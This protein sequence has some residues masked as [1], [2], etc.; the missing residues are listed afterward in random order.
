M[1]KILVH[2]K[3]RPSLYPV[4]VGA[5]VEQ[6]AAI[7]AGLKATKAAVICSKNTRAIAQRIAAEALSISLPHCVLEIPDGEENKSMA[8]LQGLLEKMRGEKLD[9]DA[10]LIAVGGGVLGDMAGFAAAVYLRG[11][12]I[13]QVP[14]TLVAMADS[15]VGGKTGVNFG[16][17]NLVGAFHQ[18][19]AVV[20]DFSVLKT[21]AA[22]E[23]RQ[24]LAEIV[25]VACIRSPEL[26]KFIEENPEKA[27]AL[28]ERTLERMVR[29]AVEIKADVVGVDERE[30]RELSR[31]SGNS[32]MLLNFGHSLGHALE[33]AS[34]YSLKHGD[35]VSIGMVGECEI[36]KRM[37]L[38]EE[39]ECV[40][41]RNLLEKLGLPTSAPGVDAGKAVEALQDD[42]KNSSGELVMVLLRKIGRGE[43][44]KGV[45]RELAAQALSELVRE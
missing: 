44:V 32:R 10:V 27:V 3:A 2:T 29:E 31:D 39:S 18:P 7:V 1:R 37:G 21:L 38:L 25:K 15:S 40:R 4:M 23:A 6:A 11:I 5:Q 8:T 42:K 20:M 9:R 19:E 41:I 12:R 24:G 16:G 45:P 22:E 26:F 43:I 14:T 33:K 35:A 34:G 13:V 17:K 28:E 36:A 30:S